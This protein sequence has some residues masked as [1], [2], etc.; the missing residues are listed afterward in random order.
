VHSCFEMLSAVRRVALSKCVR[1]PKINTG[2]RASFMSTYDEKERFEEARYF[3]NED[4][5]KIAEMKEKV[6]KILSLDDSHVSK[7]G[8][9][10]LL[11]EKKA[12]TTW[13]E[14]LMQW[15]YMVPI[16]VLVAVPA[17]KN[18][19]L[20][21][22]PETQLL[23]VFMFV[24]AFV[25]NE[26]G[27]SIAKA[28]DDGRNEIREKLNAVEESELAGVQGTITANNELLD[29]ESQVKSVH[30]LTDDIATVQ[31]EY[32]NNLEKH[33]IR[34]VVAKKL[35][36]LAALEDNASNAI[37][38]RMLTKVH[39]DVLN[40]FK[41]D[42]KAKEA[43]L[44]QAFAVLNNIKGGA[45]KPTKDVVGDYFASSLKNYKDSYSKLPAGSDEIINQLEKDVAAV[46]K[47][48]KGTAEGG[49]VYDLNKTATARGH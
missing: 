5:R 14:K 6:E 48:P 38:N 13:A 29:L 34:D 4:K 17:L 37:R 32:L 41:T 47:I 10:E 24:V 9:V 26:F 16:G 12:K 20:V 25:H 21:I 23:G 39:D 44:Q 45:A 43:A 42:A 2:I 3:A 35:D 40:T 22:D 1:L 19:W 8:L 33:K 27:P 31:A 28:L 49:N 18:E 11:E 36:Q 30:Q 7:Q 15:N 46:L